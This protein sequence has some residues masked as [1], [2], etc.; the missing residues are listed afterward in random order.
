MDFCK[1]LTLVYYKDYGN[2]SVIVQSKN[3]DEVIKYS[4]AFWT[5]C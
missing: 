3:L 4:D 1:A 2:I 5:N